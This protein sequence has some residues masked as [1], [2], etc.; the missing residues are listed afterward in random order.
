MGSGPVGPGSN[1]GRA[2]FK[3]ALE[4]KVSKEDLYHF[5]CPS[6]ECRKWW[7]VGDAPLDKRKWYCP[8]CGDEAIYDLRKAN[9]YNSSGS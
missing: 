5:Q 3:M 7:T 2:I 1:P 6:E 4:G 9:D 8:W